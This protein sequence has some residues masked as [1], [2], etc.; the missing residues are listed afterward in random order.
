MLGPDSRTDR[1]GGTMAAVA[2]SQEPSFEALLAGDLDT[3][4][5][6][7]LA[8]HLAAR[9]AGSCPR[10]TAAPSTRHSRWPPPATPSA[11]N[12]P[13]T[14]ISIARRIAAGQVRTVPGAPAEV[15]YDLAGLRAGSDARRQGG[16]SQHAGQPLSRHRAAGRHGLVAAAALSPCARARTAMPSWPTACSHRPTAAGG[17]RRAFGHRQVDAGAVARQPDRPSSGARVLRPTYSGKRL[18][19]VSPETSAAAQAL[20]APQ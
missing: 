20:H 13:A 4:Q 8:D 7:T 10:A 19:G 15:L 18:A 1:R 11:P 17:D 14:R 2:A 16:R 5:L 9:H 6:H 12:L 3:D